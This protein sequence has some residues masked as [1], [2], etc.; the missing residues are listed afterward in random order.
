MILKVRTQKYDQVGRIFVAE[1][2]RFEL[3]EAINLE[4]FQD[5]CLKPLGHPSII[6]K[7]TVHSVLRNVDQPDIPLSS[8]LLSDDPECT[9]SHKQLPLFS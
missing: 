4:G 5:L 7:D 2:A 3:A 6:V 8:T 1:G 9:T